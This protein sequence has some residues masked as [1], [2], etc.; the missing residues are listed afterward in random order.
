MKWLLGMIC[1]LVWPLVVVAQNERAPDVPELQVDVVTAGEPGG[2]IFV[3]QQVLLRITL[4]SRFPF[5][6]L[7]IDVP[8]IAD[9]E[10]HVASRPRTSEF[11]TYGGSGWRHQRVIALFPSRSGVLEI[12]SVRAEGAV[13]RADGTNVDFID[14]SEAR[15]LEV[16]PAHRYLNGFW[17]VA[18]DRIELADDWS[19]D[20][21]SL[22]IGDTVRRTVTMLAEGVTADRLPELV[23]RD[24][25]GARIVAVAGARRTRFTPGGA[26]AEVTRSWDITVETESAVNVPPVSVTWWN[27]S[28]S[29]PA[30]S[31]I[32]AARIEPL[33]V[34]ADR[35]R[36][37]LMAEAAARRDQ[38]AFYLALLVVILVL[39]VTVLVGAFLLAALPSMPDLRLRWRLRTGS[40]IEKTRALVT[41]A[42]STVA[43]DALTLGEIAADAPSAV[44]T[45]LRKIEAATFGQEAE[46]APDSTVFPRWSRQ[47]RLQRLWDHV[48]SIIQMVTGSIK[49][50]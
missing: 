21:A 33:A 46:Q 12:P 28:E 24:T 43:P 32:P 38:G 23:Q 20:V 34:D 14:A 13:E 6:K 18:A 15:V 31:G 42:R 37:E 1:I 48:S 2:A 40:G 36:A 29:R 7:R 30:A 11:S 10:R 3:Q 9:T 35:L 5:R 19:K 45:A 25:P 44:S 8:E 49:L 47:V 39:P 4:V 27:T 41:W 22:R 50:S 16:R 26:T 17:W